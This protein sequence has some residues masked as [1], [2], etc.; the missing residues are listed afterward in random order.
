MSDPLATATTQTPPA[1]ADAPIA[2]TEFCDRCIAHAVAR[3]TL[4]GTALR[5][6]GHHL[7]AHRP[8]LEANPLI[9]LHVEDVKA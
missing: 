3:A 1:A 6:C 5:F 2:P 4:Q 9:H 8:A 7:R